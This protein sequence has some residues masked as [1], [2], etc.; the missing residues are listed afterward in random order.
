R[1]RPTR[2]SPSSS[3]A[4]RPDTCRPCSRSFRPRCASGSSNAPSGG[5]LDRRLIRLACLLSVA[6]AACTGKYVRPT[7][8]EKIAP[9]PE[10]TARGGYLVNQVAACGA[11]HTPR[12]NLPWL[13]GERADAYLAGGTFLDDP[14][15]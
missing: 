11:C 3:T 6:L 12:V 7:T 5:T 4:R 8:P 13:E 2:A 9:T 15:Y 1:W 14:S 10:L